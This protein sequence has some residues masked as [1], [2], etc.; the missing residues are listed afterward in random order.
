MTQAETIRRALKRD[1]VLMPG[2]Y[3][4]LSARIANQTGFKIIFISGY[5]VSATAL[6][7]PDFGLLSLGDITEATRRVCKNSNAPVIVDADTGYG[8]ALNVR[9]TVCELLD[10]GAAG[11]FLEDQ[12]WPKRC[13]H[14]RGKKV[15]TAEEHAHKIRAAR[16]AAEESGRDLFIVARTD[17][18]Q[19][20]GLDAAIERCKLYKKAGADALFV[21]APLSLAELRKIGRELPRPLV[22]NMIERGVTPQLTRKQLKA[23]GFQMIVCPLAGLCAAAKAVTEIYHI[24]KTK[25]TTRKDLDLVLT[26]DEFNRI[27]GLQ[28]KYDTEKRYAVE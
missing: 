14:M 10:A 4:A 28:Q 2:V 22:A 23:L 8:N 26:F 19:P 16:D 12:V 3:D 27:I 11:V 15:I 5:S 21:E 7:E 20:L 6:G 24:L 18:R 9:R 17:A 1:A 13:G 25:E